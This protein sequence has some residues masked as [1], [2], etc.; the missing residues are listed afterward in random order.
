MRR[1][2]SIYY[3]ALYALFIAL[4]AVFTYVPFIGY[5]SLGVVSMTTVHILV[6]TFAFLTGWKHGWAFGLIFGVFSLIKAATQP[7]SFL[8]PYFV[9]PLIS[10]FPRIAF[11]FV[12]GILFDLV[13]KT[14]KNKAVQIPLFIF[15]SAFVTLL[16]SVLVLGMLGVCYFSDVNNKLLENGGYWVAFGSTLLLN[17]LPE[18]A[19]A[20]V[21]VTPISLAVEIPYSYIF[22]KKYTV[23]PIITVTPI[24]KKETEDIKNIEVQEQPVN[25]IKQI[26]NEIENNDKK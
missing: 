2:N 20:G 17:T 7:A 10:I 16:H 14:I 5:I 15:I 6:L 13:K 21:L 24:E 18:M 11:A 3:I 19:L 1:N 22:R 9:N 8:D 26:E 25:K 12:A 23:T 4:M